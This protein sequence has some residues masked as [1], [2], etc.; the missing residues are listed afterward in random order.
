MIITEQ[1][2]KKVVSYRTDTV[3]DRCGAHAK[4]QNY[5]P[6]DWETLW[7]NT[8]LCAACQKACRT[9]DYNYLKPRCGAICNLKEI[10]K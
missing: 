4:G 2:V 3:C 8:H 10:K 1:Y 6:D 5:P 7:G 9:C